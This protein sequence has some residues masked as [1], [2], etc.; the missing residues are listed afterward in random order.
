MVGGRGAD[1]IRPGYDE[2]LIRVIEHMGVIG[3]GVGT[4]V[5]MGMRVG[6]VVA[7][8]TGFDGVLI[9]FRTHAVPGGGERGRVPRSDHLGCDGVLIISNIGS[10]SGGGQGG[11][12]SV[13]RGEC[14]DTKTWLGGGLTKSNRSR[15][16]RV[17][18]SL[19][20]EVFGWAAARGCSCRIG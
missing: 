12:A 5:G 6:V 11:P 4:G 3:G 9:S 19:G 1:R 18:V 20:T 8:R 7:D 13:Q 10:G 2:V 16:D 15:C 14:E 17:L